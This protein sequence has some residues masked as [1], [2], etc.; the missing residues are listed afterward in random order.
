[1][2]AL[3]AGLHFLAAAALCALLMVP[4]VRGLRRQGV[5]DHPN[6]RSLHAAPVPRGGGLAVVVTVMA[7]HAYGVAQGGAGGSGPLAAWALIALA[8]GALGWLDDFRPRPAGLRLVVQFVLAALFVTLVLPLPPLPPPLAVAAAS[9]LTVCVVWSVNLYNFMDGA[10]GFAASQAL[11]G[12]G[13]ALLLP[14]TALS[15]PVLPVALALAGACAG[16]LRWNRPPARVFMGD[17]GSYF[18]GF[19]LAAVALLDIRAGGPACA[20]LILFLPFL[21]D[22]TLTLLWR[23]WRGQR[24]WAAHRDHAYQR[25]VIDGWS[26]ARLL[27]ALAVLNVGL[28]WPLAWWARQQPSLAPV[29]LGIGVALV[30]S[31]WAG[32]V[33]RAPRA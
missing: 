10:D 19:E 30:A 16:F 15:A 3:A 1:M 26:H 8:C 6:A 9:A 21:V 18:I 23:M 33:M 4:I 17:V 7:A 32:I 24:W 25:L 12:V 11:L 22:A 27:G 20:W 13:G 2:S 5:L 29:A 31:L 14:G 28:C